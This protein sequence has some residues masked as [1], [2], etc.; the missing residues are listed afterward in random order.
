MVSQLRSGEWAALVLT[1]LLDPSGSG[2]E[3]SAGAGTWKGA[4]SGVG[5]LSVS[6]TALWL[7][8]GWVGHLE[9]GAGESGH[10][11]GI[12]PVEHHRGASFLRPACLILVT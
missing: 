11:R 3:L 10:S 7:E 5:V 12:S 4:I 1:R 8:E 2:L 9:A 6:G